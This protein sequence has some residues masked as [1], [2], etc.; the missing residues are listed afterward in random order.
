MDLKHTKEF[1]EEIS[2]KTQEVQKIMIEGAKPDSNIVKFM[3]VLNNNFDAS[4]QFHLIYRTII[5]E[6]L[7]YLRKNFAN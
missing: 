7:Y 6:N 3:T 4:E 2:R 5:Y 1:F